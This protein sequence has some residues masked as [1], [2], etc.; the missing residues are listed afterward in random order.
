M[1]RLTGSPRKGLQ[2]PVSAVN[3]V[4]PPPPPDPSPSIARPESSAVIKIVHPE[5]KKEVTFRS[6]DMTEKIPSR[7]VESNP[8][9]ITPLATTGSPTPNL[10]VDGNFTDAKQTETESRKRKF[11]Y[12]DQS[13]ETK[14]I[15]EMRQ[16]MRPLN[17]TTSSNLSISNSE[18][19]KTYIRQ[20]K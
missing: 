13:T 18:D 10:N 9:E 6:I 14:D 3:V 5:T 12:F 7:A 17:F 20:D 1:E 2:P 19:Q 4:H 8:A 16:N 15:S 11:S